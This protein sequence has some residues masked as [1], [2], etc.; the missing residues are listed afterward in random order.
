LAQAFIQSSLLTQP[1]LLQWYRDH[2]VF[3]NET[4]V[5]ELCSSG[6]MQRIHVPQLMFD[7]LRRS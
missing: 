3:E 4:L 7:A 6:V 1:A 5:N 2:V